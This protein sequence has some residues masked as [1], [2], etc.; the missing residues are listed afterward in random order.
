MDENDW[1]AGRFEEHRGELRA[2]A[3]RMLGSL[4]EAGGAVQEAWLRISGPLHGGAPRGVEAAGRYRII[5]R[6]NPTLRSIVPSLSIAGQERRA[7]SVE[8]M[9]LH[10]EIGERRIQGHREILAV[11]RSRDP[12]AVEQAFRR[13]ATAG[14]ELLL[15]DLD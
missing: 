5:R 6:G 12:A 13:H 11:L 7:R 3:Y 8:T 9:R 15:N 14:V 10:T 4:S 2:V 1:L